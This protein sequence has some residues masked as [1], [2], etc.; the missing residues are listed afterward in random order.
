[1]KLIFL[2]YINR[3][4]STF[5]ANLLSGS[6]DVLVLPEADILVSS[7][8]EDPGR[9][10]NFNEKNTRKLKEILSDDPKLKHWRISL[11]SVVQPGESLS[12]FK[13]F[14]RILDGYRKIHK[15]RA[16]VM[17]FKAE[18]IIRLLPGF[19]ESTSDVDVRFLGLIRDPRGT[20]LS[21]RDT[22]S[23]MTG[24]A[25][26]TDPVTFAIQWRNFVRLCEQY[27]RSNGLQI[28]QFEKLIQSQNTVLERLYPALEM[29]RFI[30]D[31]AMGDL[32]DRIPDD[33]KAIHTNITNAPIPG[34]TD[35]WEYRLSVEEILLIERTTGNRMLNWGY[36]LKQSGHGSFILRRAIFE[37]NYIIKTFVR[38]LFFHINPQRHAFSG[39]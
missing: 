21:Q 38:K 12:G 4:G 9:M 33:H 29:K 3:S 24:E 11:D 10:I 5:L 19:K 35:E 8:L 15:P 13:V 1:M 26:C 17:I 23:P 6:E 18:R 22:V 39:K 34:K 20:F 16:S 27:I 2:T 36:H 32:Y 7:F 25:F 28:V 37:I 30:A 31:P 14:C